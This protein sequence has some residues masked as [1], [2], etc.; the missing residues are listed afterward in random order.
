[1]K[2]FGVKKR[3]LKQHAEK[4]ADEKAV[5]KQLSSNVWL[6]LIAIVAVAGYLLGMQNNQIAGLLAPVFGQKVYTGEVDLSS[7]EDTFRAL[8]ANYDGNLND[9]ALIEGANKG[10]V[11]AAGDKYTIYMNAEEAANYAN[12]LAGNIG[13][14]IGAEIGIRNSK[15]T[16]VR[17][18]DSNPAKDAGLK[19]GDVIFSI[20][21]QSTE[22]WTVEQTVAKIRGDV[23]TTVKL[24]ILRGNTT[25]EFNV[26]RR[27]IVNPS[28]RY[29]IR[30]SVGILTI[31]RFDNETASL[32]R[33]A[34]REFVDKN[35]KGVV[36]D[37]RYNGGGYVDAAQDVAGLWLDNK[38]VV[39]ERTGNRVTSELKSSRT[40][41][42]NGIPTAV[43]VNSGSASASEIVAGALQDHEAAKIVGETT[44]GKGSVQTLIQLPEG[45]QL[46]VTIAK[47]YTP[48]GKNITE[49]GIAPDVKIALTQAD[50]D[51]N[52]DPQL[53]AAT[54]ALGL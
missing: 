10:L 51:A 40:P 27:A 31:D 37:L 34:A 6:M 29:E 20:N 22:G 5:K 33:A 41:L 50:S 43:L 36:L 1:M 26:E 54:N 16:I 52:K 35:V 13:G 15:T 44:Y 30:N 17:V 49:N 45:A 48:N 24:S 46:K 12:D 9:E 11:S 7:V 2:L 19:A 21:D 23:G 47:W 53:D 25:N 18:L 28:V 14:G 38:T 3:H 8:K 32:A 4:S 39:T 42:L